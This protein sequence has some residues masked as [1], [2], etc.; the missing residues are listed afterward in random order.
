M[1]SKRFSFPRSANL[2]VSSGTGSAKGGVDTLAIGACSWDPGAALLRLGPVVVISLFAAL[3]GPRLWG[4]RSLDSFIMAVVEVFMS[5]GSRSREL[6]AI[7][8][9][10]LVNITRDGGGWRWTII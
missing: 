1:G 7:S 4:G 3:Y 10:R 6:S 2:G 8:L 5:D 9:F